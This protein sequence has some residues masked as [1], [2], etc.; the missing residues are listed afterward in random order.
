LVCSKN[1]KALRKEAMGEVVTVMIDIIDL[2]FKKL[3]IDYTL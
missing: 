2:C 3:Q 1:K